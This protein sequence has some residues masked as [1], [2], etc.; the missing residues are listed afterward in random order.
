MSTI[1]VGATDVPRGMHATSTRREA[2]FRC[3]H[4]CAHGPLRRFVMPF[5]QASLIGEAIVTTRIRCA[6]CGMRHQPQETSE[7]EDADGRVE[8]SRR[9][10][11]CRPWTC[12]RRDY[13]LDGHWQRVSAPLLRKLCR[14]NL[15]KRLTGADGSSLSVPASYN[16][17]ITAIPFLGCFERPLLCFALAFSMTSQWFVASTSHFP[18]FVVDG[19]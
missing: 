17:L 9:D 2:S 12:T 15:T 18:P 7:I 13:L 6:N 3:G 5:A 1:R 16:R 4:C 14:G 19:Y 8:R 11:L 10:V